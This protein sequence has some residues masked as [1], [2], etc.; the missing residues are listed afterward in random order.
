MLY[1]IIVYDI[2]IMYHNTFYKWPAS[3]PGC[4]QL[5]GIRCGR[6]RAGH[7][8][9]SD[10][11]RFVSPACFGQLPAPAACAPNSRVRAPFAAAASRSRASSLSSV[12][13]LVLL[14]VLV[15]SYYE[16]S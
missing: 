8:A 1:H 6:H 12:L 15:L 9:A 7:R 10:R 2:R 16:Y 11:L 3:G 14:L 5:A 4:G 13:V